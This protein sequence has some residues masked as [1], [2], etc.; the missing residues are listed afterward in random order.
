MMLKN[1][2]LFKYRI[3]GQIVKVYKSEP[4]PVE[5]DRS[6]KGVV[7][8]ICISVIAGLIL[9]YI[10]LFSFLSEGF[11]IIISALIGAIITA[12][13]RPIPEKEEGSEP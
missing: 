7:M 2:L 3:N 4:M 13:V 10:P 5:N 11:I 6:Y 9:R 1:E 8:A 12:A